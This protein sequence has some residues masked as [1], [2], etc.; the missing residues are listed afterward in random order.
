MP[1][2]LTADYHAAEQA[3]RQA[4]TQEQKIAA[5]QQMFA[6]LPKHK[7]TEKLQAEIRR[8]L[9][10]AR[11]EGQ[12]KGAAHA[13]PAYLVRP[14][15]AGQVVLIGPPNSGKSLL[16]GRLTHAKVEVAEYPFTTRLP[17]PGMMRFEDVQIQLVDTPPIS[18]DFV[19]SWI[20]QVIRGGNACALV[21]DPNDAAVLDE[22][23]FVLQRL[24]EWHLP[25]PKV[26]V[27]NKID[28][29]SAED[30]YSALV[31]LYGDRFRCVPVSAATG[32]GLDGFAREAFDALDVV[33]FYS[34]PPGKPPDRDAPYVIRRGSC[35][36][37]AAAR[38]HR[39]FAEHLKYA[40][41]F[42]EGE[43]H[44]GLMVERTHVVA[45]RDILEFH[46]E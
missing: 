38:V 18:A 42:H 10:E 31:G 15:G 19:E 29:P 27:G 30:N 39:D 3:Y 37:E 14:E 4:Q 40:R 7:G 17:V 6:T 44:G 43:A 21:I 1:A 24:S 20:P 32:L 5:L 34:K 11:K 46:S 8:K 12:K 35:V 2:N 45:D 36:Q 25:F 33:R 26:L 41:L 23:E 9:S 22:T 16:V 13:A 28:Q